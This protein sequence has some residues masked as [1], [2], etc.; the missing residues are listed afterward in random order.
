M[1]WN[2]IFKELLPIVIGIVIVYLGYSLPKSFIRTERKNKFK[3]ATLLEKIWAYLVY[4]GVAV[5]VSAFIS[6]SGGTQI[7]VWLILSVV[8]VVIS[9]S[10]Y[11]ERDAKMN[12][13]DRIIDQINMNKEEEKSSNYNSDF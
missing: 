11:F 4:I 6:Y 3:A 2:E 10:L 7:V 9:L 13:T 12:I 5:F 1:N 8:P